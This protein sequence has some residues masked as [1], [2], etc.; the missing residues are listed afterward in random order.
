MLQNFTI[1]PLSNEQ[2]IVLR[3]ETVDVE[4]TLDGGSMQSTLCSHPEFG[5]LIVIEN[6]C[7]SS[8]VALDKAHQEKLS[9]RLSPRATH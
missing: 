3:A 8:A 5:T 9:N 2:A 7:G 6:T 4:S 1:V